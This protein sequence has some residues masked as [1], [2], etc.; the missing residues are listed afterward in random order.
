M[1]EI[2]IDNKLRPFS[3]VNYE[4]SDSDKAVLIVNRRLT[5]P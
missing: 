3:L 5:H 2:I 1:Q 4:S